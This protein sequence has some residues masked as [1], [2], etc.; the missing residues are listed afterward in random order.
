MR[1]YYT[2]DSEYAGADAFALA[3]DA[4]ILKKTGLLTA[5][6]AG[7][8]MLTASENGMNGEM[9]VTVTSSGYSSKN[10]ASGQFEGICKEA[11][12]YSQHRLRA[13]C[14]F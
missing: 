1:Q 9:C 10:S 2:K 14:R 12:K 6:N 3:I 5:E 13:I 11:Q 4:N 7:S 8:T